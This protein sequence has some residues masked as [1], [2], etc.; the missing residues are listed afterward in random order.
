MVARTARRRPARVG[1]RAFAA[2]AVVA[3]GASAVVAVATSTSQA[4]LNGNALY[5]SPTG[6]AGAAG[7]ASAPTTLAS[8]ISKITPGGTIYLRGGTYRLSST[9]TIPTGN[10]GTSSA[11]KELAAYPGETPVL[12]FSAQ[13]EAASNRGLV[14]SGNYWHLYGLVVERAG[15]NGIYVSGSNNV[16]ERTVTRFNRDTG[17]QI[18]RAA[19]STPRSGWPANNLVVTSESHDNKDALGENADGFAA[20]LT[21]G[22][23][24]VFRSTVAHHNV[25]DGWDL[26]AKPDTGPIDPVTIEDSLAYSNGTLSDG[27]QLANGDRNGFK[28]G[29]SKIAVNHVIRRSIAYRNGQHGFTWNS[30]PGRITV[31]DNV[32][33]DNTERNFAFDGGVSVFRNDTSCR[34]TG[35]TVDKTSGDADASNQFWSGRNGSRCATYTGAMAWSFSGSGQLVVSFGG[36]PVVTPRPTPTTSSAGPTATSTATS[37]STTKPPTTTTTTTKPPTAT[38][39]TST[40]AGPGGTSLF[41]DDFADGDSSGWT[42]GGGTWA[43]GAGALGQSAA[44]TTA[45]VAGSAAW[46]ATDV[47]VTATNKG[48]AGSGSAVSVLAR[49]QSATSYYALALR[50]ANVVELRKVVDG[51][52]TVLA[53]APFKAATNKAFAL[54][55]V[56]KGTT[57]TG[58][59]GGTQV[60]SA[61]DA[62]VAAG[63]VGVGTNNATA[64]FDDVTVNVA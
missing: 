52:S 15:D 57:L 55:L 4:A 14:L 21:V 10:N 48:V 45:A 2:A 54:R 36:T 28:L 63:R 50:D 24:N 12:N 25:D 62:T 31:S 34:S 13:S 44:G 3:V 22:P 42:T 7:T 29:G 5:V 58:S 60:V 64:S 40:T 19:S 32:S 49:A 33:I 46:T 27:T 16:V 43:V 11:R 8:A 9:V 39:T 23:G 61:T 35:S 56:V 30:N 37:T 51:K 6:S 47:R 17:L 59:V 38:T 18:G 20:K 53:S 26:F 41:A 1:A